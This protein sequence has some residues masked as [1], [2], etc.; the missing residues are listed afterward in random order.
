MTDPVTPY[1]D[2]LA[3]YTQH[4]RR[5]RDLHDKVAAHVNNLANKQPWDNRQ[6]F[7]DIETALRAEFGGNPTLTPVE[8]PRPMPRPIPPCP[9]QCNGEPG[10]CGGCGHAGCGGRRRSR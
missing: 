10:F 9:C 5:L 4:M 1:E 7:H 6:M 2:L 3:E 8:P